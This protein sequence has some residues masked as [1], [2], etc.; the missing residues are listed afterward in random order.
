MKCFAFINAQLDTVKF[1]ELETLTMHDRSAVM[2][3][4]LSNVM[5]RIEKLAQLARPS[6]VGPPFL[7]GKLMGT[8]DLRIVDLPEPSNDTLFN[9]LQVS[10]LGKTN[11]PGGKKTTPPVA[12]AAVIAD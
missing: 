10:R 2:I 8:A 6:I 5:F 3:L 11:T 7:G 1:V 9:D 4:L 12:E